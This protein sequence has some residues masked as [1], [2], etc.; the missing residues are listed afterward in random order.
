V[1]R[2]GLLLLTGAVPLAATAQAPTSNTSHL[3]DLQAAFTGIAERV[4]P[5]VC[6]VFST[7]TP[8]N[9][10][11]LDR[12]G[13]PRLPFRS[14]GSPHRSTSTGSG[15]IISADGWVLTNEHVAGAADR[16]VVRLHDGREFVG[17]V[18][19]DRQSDLALVKINAPEP[20]PVAHFGDSDQVKIG[21][22]AIAIG[23]PFRYEGSLSVGVVSSLARSER[24]PDFTIPTGM[25]FYA[26][27]IQTDAA[28]N[29]GN[30]GGPLCDLDGNI[31]GINTAIES[32]SG[33][34][35]GIGFAIPINAAKFVVAQ[36][37]AKGH[38]DYG[39]LGIRPVTVTPNEASVLGV[40]FGA[41]LSVDPERGSPAAK[42]GLTAGDIVTAI[43]SK[44]IRSGTDLQKIVSHSAPDTKIRLTIVHEGHTQTLEVTL[45]RLPDQ[46]SDPPRPP[47]RTSLGI[48]VQALTKG[49]IQ[50]VPDASR[51]SGVVIRS[52][53]PESAASDLPDITR[54][55]IIVRVNDQPTPTVAAFQAATANIKSGDLIKVYFLAHNGDYLRHFVIVPVD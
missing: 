17:T 9:A 5:V 37:R 45:A 18:R 25:R 34:S 15:V 19:G 50:D 23:S 36:L 14:P 38:V 46:I 39:F 12:G 30:S 51:F 35:V 31:V 11:D 20:L 24:I 26:D 47:G 48:E 44:P 55:D 54:G 29:P 42:A 8:R 10:D 33:G 6:T 22:W 43:D 4:E 7:T 16:V 3:G 21:Q 52:I 32:E 27:L 28:I 40:P 53:A 49:L 13:T 2:F 1:I 41:L